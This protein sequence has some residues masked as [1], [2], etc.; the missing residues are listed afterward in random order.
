MI[1]E[2]IPAKA[3]I[4]PELVWAIMREE[5]HYRVDA[6]SSVG[7]L[8]L[9]QIMPAT[10]RQLAMERGL[11]DFEA[12]DLFDPRTNIMLGSTYLSQ[13]GKRFDGR[14]SAAIGS[15]N[16]GPRKVSSWLSGDGGKLEDDVWV[17]N[18]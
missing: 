17:E 16:A 6:R 13:L 7:A 12:E 2:V 15:Y 10:A 1:R 5:S 14:M 8:G 3:E 11:R 4:E 9:L 18:L